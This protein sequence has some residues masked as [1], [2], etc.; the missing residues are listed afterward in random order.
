MTE[1]NEP[2]Q[3]QWEEFWERYGLG[4]A[5]DWQF[6]ENTPLWGLDCVKCGKEF[7]K[8]QWSQAVAP[9][10]GNFKDYP[11]ID[12]NNLFKFVPDVIREV[13]FFRRGLNE[14][15]CRLWKDEA[16]FWIE[17]FTPNTGDWAKD[18]A[19]ALFWAIHSLI[20]K[21]P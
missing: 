2:T 11:P 12:L 14:V 21:T 19:L 3:K 8:S 6:L 17:V 15:G 7:R 1:Q 20:D 5:H 16:V 10:I 13:L 4:C 9:A 18:C